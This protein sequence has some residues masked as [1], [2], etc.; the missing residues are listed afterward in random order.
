M[1]GKSTNFLGRGT[2]GRPSRDI[3]PI[4]LTSDQWKN[5]VELRRNLDGYEKSDKKK[6]D[7]AEICKRFRFSQAE[8][9]RIR[10]SLRKDPRT[11]TIANM[12]YGRRRQST[13]LHREAEQLISKC[14]KEYFGA[15]PEGSLVGLVKFTKKRFTG[16]Y[17]PSH[18]TIVRRFKQLG[19]REKTVLTEGRRAAADKFNLIRGTTPQRS[20]P[21]ERVQ[22]DHTLCDVW[23]CDPQHR[24]PAQRPWITIALCEYSR[25]ILAF[26][27]T[28]EHPGRHSV[29]HVLARAVAPKD[30]WLAKIGVSGDW[31]FFGKMHRTFTDNA[32]EFHSKAMKFGCQEWGMADP[33]QR[34]PGGTQYGG[35][36]E[37]IIGT[38][39]EETK[40]LPGRTARKIRRRSQASNAPGKDAAVFT[41]EEYE[42]WLASWCIKYHNE[43]HSALG[44][45]PIVAWNRG[46]FGHDNE[47]GSGPPETIDDID[48]FFTDFLE[49]RDL[50][51]GREGFHWDG[52]KYLD[53]SLQTLLDRGK[54]QKFRVCRDP[55]DVSQVRYF[56]P[57]DGNYYAVPCTSAEVVGFTEWDVR[58]AKRHLKSYDAAPHQAEIISALKQMEEIEASAKHITKSARRRARSHHKPTT[59]SEHASPQS[60]QVAIE[61]QFSSSKPFV[62]EEIPMDDFDAF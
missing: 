23:L 29:A 22:I 40:M 36:I 44:V 59:P 15:N 20:F 51:L 26:F 34:P 32:K 49:Q 31:P 8:F 3:Q 21:L 38:V 6:I 48:R 43:V 28:F 25:A 13:R 62:L 58:E 17:V 27:L 14:R 16:S 60:A 18:S 7:R 53:D 39:M 4:F 42:R 35:Q 56:N 2:R 30:Q 55:Y 52:L 54:G 37:R 46:I 41:I 19:D 12:K 10:T 1:L 45:P 33:E 24:F 47:A 11:S 61:D 50:V 5:L 9:Y 57:D